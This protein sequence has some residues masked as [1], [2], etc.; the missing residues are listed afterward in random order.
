MV[1]SKKYAQKLIKGGKARIIGRTTTA[2]TWDERAYGETY[3]IVDRS[4]LQRVD[5]IRCE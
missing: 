1:I 3:I 2:P 5:H 4:D